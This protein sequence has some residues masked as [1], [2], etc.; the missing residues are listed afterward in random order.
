VPKVIGIIPSRYASRRFP[1]KPLALLGGLPIIV[2]VYN[3]AKKATI[4]DDIIVATD[5]K[6]I[7]DAVLE[8]DG[9]AVMT[10]GTFTCGSERVAYAA[11]Q[12]KA[13][14][15]INIQGDE[16]LISPAVIEKV[17]NLLIDNPKAKMST[18]CSPISSFEEIDNPNVVKL[19]LDKNN[20]ALYF[21]R[22]RI[23][24]FD[25]SDK[26]ISL[27]K[28]PIYHHFGIYGFT[29]EFL[30]TFVSLGQSSLE[31]IESLEQLRVLE[32]GYDIYCAIASQ[33]YSGIDSQ[34]DLF[35]AEQILE[36]M[37]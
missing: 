12:L 22:S 13:D 16:P 19:V 1:G 32:N 15:I 25:T 33:I 21:S 10:D 31:K 24:W 7:Y 5:D 28:L 14:I 27:S 23:P 8:H 37:G 36:S 4:L 9:K 34:E 3:Q 17:A 11:K 2:R 29:A 26:D 20:R 35:K 30:Q 18:A 6:R